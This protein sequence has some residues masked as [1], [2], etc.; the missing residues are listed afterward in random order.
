MLVVFTFLQGK[1]LMKK[2]VG[3]VI[4]RYT[5]VKQIRLGIE[6]L[7]TTINGHAQL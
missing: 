7:E 3:K 5:L 6:S 4:I 1:H 2:M